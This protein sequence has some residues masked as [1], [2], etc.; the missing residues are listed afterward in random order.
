MEERLR[1]A[2]EMEHP[3]GYGE[4][5]PP[6]EPAEKLVSPIGRIRE[7][8]EDAETALDERMVVPRA[9]EKGTV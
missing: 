4:V 1:A 2:L 6:Q 7:E 9:D 8:E 5:E 3:V